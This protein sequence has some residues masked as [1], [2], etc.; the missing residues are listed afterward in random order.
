[1]KDRLVQ[2]FEKT[3]INGLDLDNRL[4]RSAT[5]EGMCTD[6]GC[7]TPQLRKLYRDL[8][9]GGVGLITTGFAFVTQD[10]KPLPGAMGLHRDDF[11]A[12][13]RDVARHALTIRAACVCPWDQLAVG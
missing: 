10:G 9:R 6:E 2:L 1:M 4:V 11:N 13:L 5:W 8:A 12:E 7:P 3:R